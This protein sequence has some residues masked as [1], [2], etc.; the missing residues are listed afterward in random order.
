[1][2]RARFVNV[3]GILCALM[4]LFASSFGVVPAKAA[5]NKPAVSKISS[6]LSLRIKI[7]TRYLA[8]A[9]S[10]SGGQVA[11]SGADIQATGEL[12]NLNREEV[13]IRFAQRPTAAQISE[14][15]TLGV[16][17][18]PDSWIPPVGNHT[19]GFILADMPVEMLDALSAK[20]Y[21]VN[22]DTAE[23]VA[24]PQNNLARAT[25]GVDSVWSGGDTGVGVTVAVLDSGIDTTNPDF[26]ALNTSNSKDYSNYPTL[27]DTI[28]NT[29]SGH[30]SHVTGSVLGRG[31]NSATYKGV[32]PGANLVFLKIGNDS[33]GS[34][35]SAAVVGA[36]RAAVD[37]YHA[38]IINMSYGG[39]SDAHDGSDPQSQAVDYAVSQ[40][41]TVFMSAG[42][43][44]DRG[45]HYSGTVAANST[46][47]FIQVNMTG[48]ER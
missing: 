31:I 27:D 42:N 30:G 41:A 37:A 8:Q 1:M 15:S 10:L 20:D 28:T 46:T 7:K 45:W 32:A 38:K 24:Y 17:T 33:I 21:V 19:T 9:G 26:P 6:L 34:A 47:A 43:N 35:S 48:G 18:Y 29:V 39:W 25:M 23:A 14:L 3:I 5:D 13:F 44:A 16:T 40:G 4:I 36:L 11:L 12:T 2:H 22:L